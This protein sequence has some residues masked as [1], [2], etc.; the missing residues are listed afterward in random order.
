MKKPSDFTTFPWS[1][2]FQ[3]SEPETIIRNIMIMLS[4]TGDKWRRMDW[5]EYKSERINDGAKDDWRLHSEKYHFDGVV[6]YT[7][8]PELAASVCSDWNKIYNA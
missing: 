6:S 4:R 5:E 8:S 1:S 3:K 7:K 2:I